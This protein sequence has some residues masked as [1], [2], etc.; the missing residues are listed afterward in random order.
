M[1]SFAQNWLLIPI[2]GN[3][4]HLSNRPYRHIGIIAGHY[5]RALLQG[6]IA[7]HYCRALFQG[8]IPGHYSRALFQ[9]WDVIA[10]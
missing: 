4:S 2:L 5:C 3:S 6:I 10:G 1:T 7:G 8:I 9:G